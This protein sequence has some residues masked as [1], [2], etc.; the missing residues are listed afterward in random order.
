MYTFIPSKIKVAEETTKIR[1]EI[2]VIDQLSDPI[3]AL[4]NSLIKGLCDRLEVRP[5]GFSY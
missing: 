3:K 2:E 4:K 5:Q 1:T